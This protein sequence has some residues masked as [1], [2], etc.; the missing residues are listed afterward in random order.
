MPRSGKHLVG[1]ISA[2]CLSFCLAAC[3]TT[4]ADFHNNA[5]AADEAAYASVFPYYAELCAV[6]QIEKKPGFGVDISGGVGGHSVLYLNGVC[7]VE[8]A[9]YPTIELC[10]PDAR[11]G[12]RGVGLSVNA[13]F[14]NANWVATEGRNFFFR[15]DLQPGERLTRE[16]YRRTQARAE[17]MGILDGVVFHRVVFDDQP[18]G[19]SKRDYMYEVSVATDYAIGFGRDRYCARIP[20]TRAQMAKVARFLNEQNEQYRSGK[21]DFEWNV[22]RDNCAHLTHNALA[23]AGVWDD[24]PTER[25]ILV[26]AFDF[27]VPKNEF[28]NLMRRTNDGSLKDPEAVYDNLAE[29]HDLLQ[30]DWLPTQPGGLAEFQS[31]VQNNDVYDTD[32]HLIFYDVP[33]VGPYEQDFQDILKERRYTDLR[34]NLR[35]F[36]LLYGEIE[37]KRQ[38]LDVYL[39]QHPGIAAGSR[40]KFAAFYTRFYR[41]IERKKTQVDSALAYLGDAEF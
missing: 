6:S 35:Y 8:G 34:A 4:H 23:A 40:P 22:L 21:K 38:P 14:K 36:R 27:P 7:R 30:D 31:A 39:Q 15:G 5:S 1:L 26:A 16:A 25:F 41:Y 32:L 10:R 9:H 12:G 37:A 33:V 13:H 19:M 17:Q 18:M 11:E 24:W 29:R 28:V 20:L 2:A 3:G